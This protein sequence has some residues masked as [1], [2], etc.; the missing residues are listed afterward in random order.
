VVTAADGVEALNKARAE[1]PDLVVLDLH[2]AG[3]RRARSLQ[4]A[5]SRRGYRRHS[6][7]HA[8][9]QSRGGLIAS[10][11]WNWE[12]TIYVTKPFSPRELVLRIKNLLQRAR[13]RGKV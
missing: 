12:L 7:H 10:W 5:A 8:D 6:H 2:A 13:P 1:R 9:G 3:D 11:D 4:D